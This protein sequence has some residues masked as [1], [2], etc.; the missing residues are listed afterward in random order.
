MKKVAYIS[1]YKDG[2][3]YGNAASLMIKAI[4][5]AGFTVT[6]V[7][8]S[9]SKMPFKH[10]SELDKLESNGLSD[11][12]VVIQQCLPDMF[13][14]I[15]GVKNIGYF[16]WETDCFIGSGWKSGCDLMDEIW[17][18]T[19][20]QKMACVKS[21]LSSEKI[22]IVDQPKEVLNYSG[23]FD[24]SPYGIENTYKFYT[25]S[26]YSNKKN[27][28]AL[29]HAFLTE[30][31]IHDNVSLVIKSYISEKSTEESKEHIKM[32][33]QELKRQIGK[34]ENAYPKIAIISNMLS[35]DELSSLENSCDCFISSSR[36]E[37]EGLPM[38]QA[39]LKG[40]PVVANCISGIKKNFKNQD[41]LVK[42]MV[43]KKVFGMNSFYYNHNESW[44]DGSTTELC[45]RLR[46]VVENPEAVSK[47]VE[48]NKSFLEE[49][50]SL[51]SCAEKLKEII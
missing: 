18:T 25:I 5:K 22:R 42:S 50:F 2:T 8:I 41:L 26:D 12:D 46:F 4:N 49:N 30:F 51:S 27:V 34:N 15:N 45:D 43:M 1:V 13:V 23:K 16:F 48:E 31:T 44:Y 28:N 35:D 6:P 14:K 9:L 11:I 40:K 19:E 7:W 38:A 29:V 37:G 10:D 21:G 17:V 36:G 33:I 3:G 32:M 24:F 20:E 39:A 47:I